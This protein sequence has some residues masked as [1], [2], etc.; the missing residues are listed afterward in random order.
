MRRQEW[1]AKAI[2]RYPSGKKDFSSFI[3]KIFLELVIYELSGRVILID[4]LC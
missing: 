3:R 4:Y 2:Q 1:P